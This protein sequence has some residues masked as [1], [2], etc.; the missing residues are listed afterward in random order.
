MS[1]SRKRFS[2]RTSHYGRCADVRSCRKAAT[3]ARMHREIMAEVALRSRA[4]MAN[5]GHAP[6]CCDR[7]RRKRRLEREVAEAQVA[8]GKPYRAQIEQCEGKAQGR[9]STSFTTP[10]TATKPGNRD[11]CTARVLRA[12]KW[13]RSTANLGR[14]RRAAPNRPRSRFLESHRGNRP[15]RDKR[16]PRNTSPDQQK[17]A[18][19]G[20]SRNAS[21]RSSRAC[22]F[23]DLTGQRISKVMTTMKF[24]ENHIN[25]MMEIWGRRRRASRRTRTPI[26]DRP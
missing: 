2:Y 19:R 22:N 26:V 18:Q 12:A 21:S 23:Q 25:V 13:P 5:G 20:K 4:Q 1:V 3:S 15:G 8:A 17:A 6:R 11:G 7:G 16:C 9:N 14:R 24:I 10:S